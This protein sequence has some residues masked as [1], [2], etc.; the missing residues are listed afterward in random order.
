MFDNRSGARF[1]LFVLSVAYHRNAE[2]E[3]EMVEGFV[4]KLAQRVVCL[5]RSTRKQ[6]RFQEFQD[7]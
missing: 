2:M 5:K 4:A 6:H 1:S 7:L 3:Y